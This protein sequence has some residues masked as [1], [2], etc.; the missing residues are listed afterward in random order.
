MPQTQKLAP[1]EIDVYLGIL[2]SVQG[3]SCFEE[4]LIVRLSPVQRGPH[5]TSGGKRN[6]LGNLK[7]F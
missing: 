4:E 6:N 2:P 1:C 5:Q 3:C 7:R